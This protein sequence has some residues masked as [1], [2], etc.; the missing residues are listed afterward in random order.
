MREATPHLFLSRMKLALHA[1]HRTSHSASC[2]VHALPAYSMKTRYAPSRH[3]RDARVYG[4]KTTAM[5]GMSTPPPS[6]PDKT[7]KKVV[8]FKAGKKRNG[9]PNVGG[10]PIRSRNGVP[11]RKGCVVNGQMTQ[12]KTSEYPPDPPPP[13][14]FASC[15]KHT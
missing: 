13:P 10:D 3:C 2:L 11:S 15:R 7:S 14:P 5:H 4:F 6:R 8:F 1:T 9:C 12:A